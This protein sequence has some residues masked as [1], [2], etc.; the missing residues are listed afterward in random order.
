[1]N[2]EKKLLIFGILILYPATLQVPN[3]SGYFELLR[4]SLIISAK[5]IS[6][7]VFVIFH[8]INL[9]HPLALLRDTYCPYFTALFWGRSKTITY[10][11]L[12]AVGGT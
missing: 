5:I 11:V 6:I 8:S 7:P 12:R 2:T 10:K 1:M 3:F 9:M 4:Y